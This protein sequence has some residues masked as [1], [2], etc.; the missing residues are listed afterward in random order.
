MSANDQVVGNLK[1]ALEA[2]GYEVTINDG[3]TRVKGEI[4]A[5]RNDVDLALTVVNVV[6]YEAQ[7]N[8]RI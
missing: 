8:Y 7:N 3:T 4:L 5:Y 6:D 2:R 1:Q